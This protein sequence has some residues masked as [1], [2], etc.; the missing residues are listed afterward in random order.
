MKYKHKLDVLNDE[1]RWC[2]GNGDDFLAVT[3]HNVVNLLTIHC[4][5][6]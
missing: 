1:R 4:N 3:V 5:N 6:L 2:S